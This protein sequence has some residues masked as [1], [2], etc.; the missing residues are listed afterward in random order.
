VN[1]SKA[2]ILWMLLITASVCH[3]DGNDES[4]ATTDDI[5]CFVVAISLLQSPNSALRSAGASSALYYLG[6]LDGREPR[7]DLGKRVAA[8]ALKMSLEDIRLESQRCGKALSARGATVTAIGQVISIS[9]V[10]PSGGSM[11]S[12]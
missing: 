7:M 9:A 2:I 12:R 11:P 8:E 4:R 5:R 10:P 6:R 1:K 3:A